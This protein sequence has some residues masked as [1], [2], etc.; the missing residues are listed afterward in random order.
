[1]EAFVAF[2]RSPLPRRR[3]AFWKLNRPAPFGVEEAMIAQVHN[4]MRDWR[5]MLIS[6]M[7]T[8]YCIAFPFYRQ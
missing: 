6:N 2:S 7:M 8:D 1:M 4:A 3:S 5:L